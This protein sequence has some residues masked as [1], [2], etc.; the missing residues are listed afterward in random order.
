MHAYVSAL[1][2]VIH[3]PLVCSG[4]QY[5]IVLLLLLLPQQLLRFR[6][7]S[8]SYQIYLTPEL[9]QI[10]EVSGKVALS[11]KDEFIST[12][13][14]FIAVLEVHALKEK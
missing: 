8:S 4:Q 1:L 9:A 3:Q 6:L 2:P 10:I 13:H 11:L 14:L 12:E 7:L 5:L